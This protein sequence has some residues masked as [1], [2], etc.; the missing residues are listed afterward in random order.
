M[1]ASN[2]AGNTFGVF[3]LPVCCSAAAARAAE[4][5]AA[6]EALDV[7][8]QQ[9]LEREATVQAATADLEGREAQVAQQKEDMTVQEVRQICNFLQNT[10]ACTLVASVGSFYQMK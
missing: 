7:R 1:Q 2:T 4:L 9:L 8:E 3:A 5:S 10:G 6:T